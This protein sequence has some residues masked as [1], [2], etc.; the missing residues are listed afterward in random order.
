[1]EGGGKLWFKNVDKSQ[2]GYGLIVSESK[3]QNPHI[4]S[5]DDVRIGSSTLFQDKADLNERS[6]LI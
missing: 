6:S 3:T 5:Y 4:S 1:M 2:M